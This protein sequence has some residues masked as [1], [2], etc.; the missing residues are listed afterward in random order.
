MGWFGKKKEA[1]KDEAAT[2]QTPVQTQTHGPWDIS[3]QKVPAN[4]LDFGTLKIPVITGLQ[5]QPVL[6]PDRQSIER[7][8]LLFANS[9]VQILVIATPK[10]GNVAADLLKETAQAFKQQGADVKQAKGRWGKELQI[11]VPVTG[12]N[13]KKGITPLRVFFVEGNRW[14]LRIDMMGTV[15]VED[16]VYRQAATLID[17]LIVERDKEPRA[18][19]SLIRLNIPRDVE[20]IES[21]KEIEA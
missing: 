2:P 18:P 20:I 12:N 4:Y 17:N 8:N 6:S 13:G 9:V 7:L 5:I 15:A 21:D 16:E 11:A 14:A 10:S 1:V 19:L 3:Q